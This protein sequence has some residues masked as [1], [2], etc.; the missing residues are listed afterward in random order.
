MSGLSEALLLRGPDLSPCAT[1]YGLP[2]LES[3]CE[4][5]RKVRA[6]KTPG[7][8]AE[9][10]D[11]VMTLLC[12]A[13]RAASNREAGWTIEKVATYLSAG[14]TLGIAPDGFVV[15]NTFRYIVLLS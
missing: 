7:N 10:G 15:A 13:A 8:F 2:L 14:Y 5:A 12:R 1:Y 9:T 3:Q 6:N 11:L 4:A